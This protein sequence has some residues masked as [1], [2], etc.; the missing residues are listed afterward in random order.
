[1]QTN[2]KNI[3]LFLTA[4]EHE[5]EAFEKKFKQTEIK[6][7]HGKEY[8]LGMFGQY[9]VAYIHMDEQGVTS[10]AS[11]PLVSQL[12]SELHPV[13]VV[14]VGIAFGSDDKVQK[15][16]DVLVS[17]KILPYD[18]QKLLEGKTEYKEIPKEVGFQLLNAFRD[19]RKWIYC[20]PNSCQAK[21]HIG[22]IL[23]G[24]RLINNFLYRNQ[25]LNDFTDQK[26]IGGEMEA[27][28]IYS[29]CRLHGVT[30]WII[31]KGICDWGFKKN[32]PDKEKDQV[33]AALAAVDYCHHVFLRNGVFDDLVSRGNNHSMNTTKDESYHRPVLIF[34][35][36]TFYYYESNNQNHYFAETNYQSVDDIENVNFASFDLHN[37]GGSTALRKII[38]F[39]NLGDFMESIREYNINEEDYETINNSYAKDDLHI[40]DITIIERGEIESVLCSRFRHLINYFVHYCCNNRED[41]I[42]NDRLKLFDIKVQY[43]DII[44]N[45]YLDIFSLYMIL[46]TSPPCFRHKDFKKWNVITEFVKQ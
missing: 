22:S 8:Y 33:N 14:M 25:L 43:E 7:T 19:Y 21:V 41:I 30:E 39:F 13:A 1:M 32:T 23:T 4:N 46:E 38:T 45:N 12:V 34:H 44:H 36:K 5:R 2:S 6:Y 11:T 27:Q 15:I 10:P 20:L 40:T 31:V 9:Y 37:I 29:M 18:S 42:M 28:G 26:P 35:N 17:D 24:S 16:G 3:F